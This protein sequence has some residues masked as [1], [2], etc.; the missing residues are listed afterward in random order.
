[1]K[2]ETVSELMERIQNK[3]GEEKYLSIYDEAQKDIVNRKLLSQNP[4]DKNSTEHECYNFHYK[5]LASWFNSD[6]VS[7]D[8]EAKSFVRSQYGNRDDSDS[9]FERYKLNF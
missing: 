9:L 4:Y 1:M 7:P 2:N 3:I 8:C 5:F 6:W